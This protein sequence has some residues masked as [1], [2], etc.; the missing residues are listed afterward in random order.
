M[1]QFQT[2]DVESPA[3]AIKH[4]KTIISLNNK[5]PL[6]G[7][8]EYE[9]ILFRFFF[10]Y[11]VIQAVPL[12][13]KYYGDLFALDWTPLTIID[14]FY[15]ARYVPRLTSEVPVFTD[16]VIIGIVSLGGTVVWSYVDKAR[17]EYN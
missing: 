13:W 12:D 3:L 11:L 6:E 17:S 5:E 10:I 8:K 4:P 2:L 1:S 14:F 15:L 7:W 9:K 16:W